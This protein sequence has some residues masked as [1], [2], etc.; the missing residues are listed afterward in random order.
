[1]RGLKETLRKHPFCEGLS[2][3]YLD[4]MAGCA[5]NVRFAAGEYLFRN[6]EEAD[7]TFLIRAGRVAFILHGDEVT[8]TAE[9]GEMVGWSWLFPPYRWH[10]DCR[11]VVPVRAFELDGPC[12]RRKC[13]S[14]SQFGFDITKRI[15][16]RAHRRLERARLH[17]MDVYRGR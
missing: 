13:E 3:P 8:E 7:S 9:Q 5:K 2:E 12:L 14:D 6:G 15:L 11:A 17:R 10:F 1:M 4:L 16:Y